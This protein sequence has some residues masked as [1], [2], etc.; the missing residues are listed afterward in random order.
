MSSIPLSIINLRTN[1]ESAIAANQIYINKSPDFQ[2]EYEAWDDKLKTRFIETML[3]GRAM[4][5]IWTIHN[6]DEE[7][8]EILDGMHRISTAIDFLNN[9]FQLNE[10]HLTCLDS[11]YGKKYF[12]DLLSD[13]QSKLRCYNFTFNLL[14]SS[15]RKDV[16]KRRDMYEI[17][18]RSSR[19]L[20]DFEFNKVLYYP[21]YDFISKFKLGFNKMFFNKQDK[22]GEIE[23]EIIDIIILS[24]SLPNSW[25]SI[26]TLREI[27]NKKNLGFSEESVNHFMETKIKSIQTRLDFALKIIGIFTDNNIFEKNKKLFNKLYLVYKFSICRFIYKFPNT[28]TFNRYKYTI[29][30][31]FQNKIF[32]SDIQQTLECS[33]R[34]ASF[35]RKLMSYIDST[36]DDVYN[37]NA[38]EN[39]RF[40]TKTEQLTKLEEQGNVCN[41]CK[42]AKEKYESDHIVEWSKGGLT[43]MENLQVLCVSCHQTKYD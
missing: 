33:S 15:Y 1:K 18:N 17:L 14:D 32:I 2:R 41:K 4:N 42:K 30:T 13:D 7:S 22:R 11:S 19:T 39:R 27:W 20:N 24:E 8:E 25:T 9:N 38:P 36:I 31:I 37:K 6:C 35:Q 43:I 29:L 5:P 21:F 12:K 10:K 26:T 23:T 34:N 40:F 3:I 16:N 28:S